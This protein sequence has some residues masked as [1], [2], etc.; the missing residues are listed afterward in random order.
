MPNYY[1]NYY[2]HGTVIQV[3]ADVRCSRLQKVFGSSLQIM[4]QMPKN[5]FSQQKHIGIQCSKNNTSHQVI[6]SL[7]LNCAH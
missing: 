3:Y 6:S 1:T 2:T 7:N 5:M 4:Q